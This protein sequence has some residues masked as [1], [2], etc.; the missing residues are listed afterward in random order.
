MHPELFVVHWG[1]FIWV[2]RAY[3]FFYFLGILLVLGGTFWLA[4]KR[5]FERNKLIIFLSSV[6]VSGFAGARILHFLTNRSA[7]ASGEYNLFSLSM[8]GFAISGGIMAALLVGWFVSK[9]I[10]LDVWKLGDTSVVFLGLGIAMARIGCFL[11]GCCFGKVTN[12]PLGVRFPEL[13]QAHQY[14]L[15]HGMGNFFGAN[16][17]HPTQ[18]YEALAAIMGSFLAVYFIRKKS[19]SSGVAILSFGLWFSFFRLVNMRLRVM[20]GTFDAPDFFY[21]VFYLGVMIICA[22]FLYEKLKQ[23]SQK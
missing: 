6:L 22:C 1:N 2:I 13:S 23:N 8:E 4:R 7:Y 11:N 21:P 10:K 17:V 5:G 20:P 14:Q 18:I 19:I 15:A 16:P 12:L 9:K 3:S